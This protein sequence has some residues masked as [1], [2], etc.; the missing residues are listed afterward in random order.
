MGSGCTI[1][2]GAV[3]WTLCTALIVAG[4]ETTSGDSGCSAIIEATTSWIL[5]AAL[6]VALKSWGAEVCGF[7]GVCGFAVEVLDGVREV[8]PKVGTL[9]STV[10]TLGLSGKHQFLW[11]YSWIAQYQR[12]GG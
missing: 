3:T 6:G 5:C 1:V 10:K 11:L 4:G 7:A 12:I 9:D 2:T 8:L